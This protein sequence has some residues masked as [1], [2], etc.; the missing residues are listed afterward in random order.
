MTSPRAAS[1]IGSNSIPSARPRLILASASPRRAELLRR[2]GIEPDLILPAD[3]DETPRKGELPRNYACRMAREKAIKAAALLEDRDPHPP[4]IVLAADTVV[5]CG[6]RIL[7]K[8]DT[9][10][11]VRECLRL[12][13]GRRH[14]VM[15][16]VAA[17][18]DQS[19]LRERLVRTR[20][21]M[22]RFT[23]TEIAAYC[24]TREGEGKAG[25][26]AI[27]GRAAALAVSMSGS[28]TNVVGLPLAETIALLRGLHFPY[29]G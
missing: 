5:S 2:A 21:A 8:A 13:S 25:G 26:Y 16:A 6:R 24:D 1:P 7:P 20:V 15:T 3:I 12:L 17:L 23:E 4:W 27:Q 28:Y 29:V 18:T 19:I 9:A 22:K 11:D 14:Q 10:E